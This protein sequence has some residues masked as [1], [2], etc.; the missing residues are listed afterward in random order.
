MLHAAPPVCYA[1]SVIPRI[2]SI[3]LLLVLCTAARA[4]TPGFLKKH[5]G[6]E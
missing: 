1:Y 5:V 2:A 3:L 4:A 6:A